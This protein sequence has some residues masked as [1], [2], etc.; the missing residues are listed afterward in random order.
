MSITITPLSEG[1]F[2][3]GHDKLFV[4]FDETLHELNHRPVGS[5]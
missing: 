5:L 3:I 4:P 2:T 1:V